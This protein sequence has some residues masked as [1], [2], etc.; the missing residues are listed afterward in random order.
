MLHH[1]AYEVTALHRC[2]HSELQAPQKLRN[3]FAKE[4]RDA[5]TQAAKLIRELG[6]NIDKMQSSSFVMMLKKVHTAAE[7][8]QH[9]IDTH[10]HL[11]LPN[12]SKELETK[13]AL[14][15]YGCM[16]DFLRCVG[17]L[18]EYSS[19]QGNVILH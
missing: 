1:C 15:H 3:E 6:R 18:N 19:L 13:P 8:P 11:V 9:K 4:L 17:Q 5:S 12:N 10:S 7:R 16:V 2:L 14:K